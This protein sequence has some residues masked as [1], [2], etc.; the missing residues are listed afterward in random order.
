MSPVTI[1]FTIAPTSSAYENVLQRFPSLALT[2][3]SPAF[4]GQESTGP[5]C[6]GYELD[7]W[8]NPSSR[9]CGRR[10]NNPLG[11]CPECRPVFGPTADNTDHVQRSR[12]DHGFQRTMTSAS[13]LRPRN[14]DEAFGAL[15]EAI[16]RA[17]KL[18]EQRERDQEELSALRTDRDQW[19]GQYE[20]SQNQT[21]HR[22][23]QLEREKQDLEMQVQQERETISRINLDIENSKRENDQR[24]IQSDMWQQRLNESNI[25]QQHEMGRKL[26]TYQSENTNL[27]ERCKGL[28][29]KIIKLKD[30]A[31]QKEEE[32]NK[33]VDQ[34][35][36]FTDIVR[37][38]RNQ[39]RAERE[40]TQTT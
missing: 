24:R 21:K 2:D 27:K 3:Q 14:V 4:G 30:T 37:E 40:K 9:A 36:A 39:K 20:R 29:A 35:N 18:Q 34:S 33:T 6:R 12:H 19:W 8:R 25:R 13:R 23:L 17:A 28:E 7:E 1:N 32:F 15:N 16:G 22:V 11:L 10:T 5:F 26:N 31:E 38:E